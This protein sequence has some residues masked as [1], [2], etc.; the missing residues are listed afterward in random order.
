MNLD[1][2]YQVCETIW[3]ASELRFQEHH[4]SQALIQFLKEEGFHVTTNAG[5]IETA[6]VASFG[7]GSPH[8]GLL[9]EY[10]ALSGLSQQ[11][12][13]LQQKKRQETNSGHGCGHHLLGCAVV[14]AACLI[15]ETWKE[16]DGTITVFGCPGE[17]G[18]SG[19][20]YMARAGLFDDLDCA[21]TWHPSSIHYVDTGSS[22]AN[23]QAY[24]HFHGISSHAAAAPH[25]GR[26]ALDGLELMNIG[27]N[28][29]R[30]HM[31]D[32]DR[33]H[34]AIVESGGKSPNVVQSEASACYLTRSTT[35]EKAKKLYDRV[36]DIAKGAALMSGTTVEIEFDKACSNM[37]SNEVLEKVLY[38]AMKQCPLPSYTTEEM[39]YAQQFKNTI[40]EET[41]KLS[42]PK[43]LQNQKELVQHYLHQPLC[44]FLAPYSHHEV[45]SMGSTDVSDV[46]WVTP[47]AQ[48][49]GACYSMG[50]P[51]HSWQLTA[52]GC[53]SIA[54][55]GMDYAAQ[56][57]SHAIKNLIKNPEW[58]EQ[59]RQEHIEKT[60]G[61]KY[62]CPIPTSVLPKTEY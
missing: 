59:A 41:L 52:Q 51:G 8:L 32:T 54:F 15:K 24:F 49:Y 43:P 9:A 5:G 55:K 36:C 25:L 42:I 16:G 46:S 4:S 2:L 45:V 6:F 60:E 27:A 26:S 53:S 1:K 39:T 21:L 10:D 35:K 48:F 30:E 17:E 47:T 18:G 12:D 20:A 14:E 56:V 37:L 19:K 29:L 40:S 62:D 11:K 22:Q 61:K 34:Y 7:S 31:E 3:E 33:V 58:I 38:E 57:L 13:C 50:T 23:I 28:F 44:Q